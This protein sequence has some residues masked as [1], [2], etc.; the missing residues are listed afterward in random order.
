[1]SF[2]SNFIR[3]TTLTSSV[4]LGGGFLTTK[5]FCTDEIVSF[6]PKEFRAFPITKIT[7][8]SPDTKAYEIALPSANHSTGSK[9]SSCIMVKGV[10]GPDGK[11]VSKPYTPTTL[12]NQKGTFELVVKSY[13]NGKVSS[14][15][16]NLKVGDSIEVKGPFP[17]LAYKANMKKNIG[18]F[19]DS[20]ISSLY[21]Y[22]IIPIIYFIPY[23]TL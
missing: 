23:D 9:V 6:S 5:S 15:L 7:K 14:H 8:I 13:S 21:I 10:P 19:K 20:I 22:K 17:K 18:K 11:E 4:A 1:M 12:N 2:Y 3:K 16:D